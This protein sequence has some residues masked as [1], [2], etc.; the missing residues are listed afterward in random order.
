M[1]KPVITARQ[2]S[3]EDIDGV[4]LWALTM[5]NGTTAAKEIAP[6]ATRACIGRCRKVSTA[7]LIG[8]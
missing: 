4:F 7:V 5:S 1:A 2:I 6:A 3:A 8:E